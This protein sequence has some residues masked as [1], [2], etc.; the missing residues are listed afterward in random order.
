MDSPSL[1]KF[2][3]AYSLRATPVP[4][5]NTE[6]KPQRA[7]GTTVICRGRVGRCQGILFCRLSDRSRYGHP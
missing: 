2:P 6:V 4:I 5:P 1:S 7:Y 3:G